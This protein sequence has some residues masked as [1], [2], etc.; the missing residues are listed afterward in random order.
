MNR[1]LFYSHDA[2]GLGHIRRTMAVAGH[3]VRRFPDA[4]ALIMTGSDVATRFPNPDGIDF[5]KLPTIQKV[6]NDEYVSR[7][8][9]LDA[10]EIFAIRTSMMRSIYESFRPDIVVVDKHPTGVRGELL[11]L[12]EMSV[13]EPTRWVLSLRD[14]LDRPETVISSWRKSGDYGI[15]EKRYDKILV[16]GMRD[17]FDPTDAYRFSRAIK[18]KVAFCGYINRFGSPNS[19]LDEKSSRQPL[20]LATP[21]GGEDGYPI[22]ES[23]IRALDYT[24]AKFAS[25]IVFGP[26]M[27]QEHRDKLRS[28]MGKTKGNVFAID[29]TSRL[30][31]F[32]RSA[33]LVVS[34]AGYNTV[35]EILAAR[36]RAILVPRVEP[37]IEQ[38]IRA[39][40]LMDRDLATMLHPERLS[41][42][43]MAL[44]IDMELEKEKPAGT[45]LEFTGLDRALDELTPFVVRGV[46]PGENGEGSVSASEDLR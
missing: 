17:L 38:L 2:L 29:F 9:D 37:R 27:A 7:D 5:V 19:G 20:V 45:G 25:V 23:F 31:R 21:G 8:L 43:L 42:E 3:L 15:L 16:W 6:G 33:D 12:L 14:I 44:A 4:S 13:G 28:L 35:S 39:R 10:D 40:R 24:S 41:P 36:T 30:E 26:Y 34:M 46:H 11:P 22:L 32:V 18:D 1:F